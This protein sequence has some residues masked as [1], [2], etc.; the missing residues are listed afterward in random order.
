MS[1]PNHPPSLVNNG[2]PPLP[3]KNLLPVLWSYTPKALLFTAKEYRL[4]LV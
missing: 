3:P 2:R 1:L 4:P